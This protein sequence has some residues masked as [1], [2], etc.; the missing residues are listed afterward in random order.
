M[1]NSESDSI[2][3]LEL[4]LAHLAYQWRKL[5]AGGQLEA[6]QAIVEEY[7]STMSRLWALG[8]DGEGLLP[9]SEL[10]DNLMPDYYIKRWQNS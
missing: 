9:D 6:A 1:S 3:D 7:H 8:W 5:H 4:R 2:N 10:P